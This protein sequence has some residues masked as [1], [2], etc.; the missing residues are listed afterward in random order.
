[1]DWPPRRIANIGC[2]YA[3]W[4][5]FAARTYGSELVLIDLEQND[6]RHFGFADQGAAYSSLSVARKF[7]ENNGIAPDRITTMNPA[8]ADAQSSENVDLAVSFLSCGFHYPVDSYY[9]YFAE[10]VSEGGSIILDLRVSTAREQ[11]ARLGTLGTVQQLLSRNK[12]RR[13][14]VTRG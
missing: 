14:V 6:E 2:G 10:K 7:L 5:L 11:S 8:V 9:S 3:F 4:D 13:V 1:M 12:V